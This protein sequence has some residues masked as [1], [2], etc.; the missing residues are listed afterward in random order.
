MAMSEARM[1]RLAANAALLSG[2]SVVVGKS[3]TGKPVAP[4]AIPKGELAKAK[5]AYE[6]T[7]AVLDE[8]ERAIFARW[9]ETGPPMTERLETSDRTV[10]VPVISTH[11]VVAHEV[12]EHLPEWKSGPMIAPTHV[13]EAVCFDDFPAD[14][15]VLAQAAWDARAYYLALAT[16]KELLKSYWPN[17]GGCREGVMGDL[18]DEIASIRGVKTAE[19]TPE[20]TEYLAKLERILV[21]HEHEHEAPLRAA[22]DLAVRQG[23]S[24]VEAYASDAVC[25]HC[26]GTSILRPAFD[27]PD[28]LRREWREKAATRADHRYVVLETIRR[29][30]LNYDLDLGRES[31]AEYRKRVLRPVSANTGA[32]D[33][34]SKVHDDSGGSGQRWAA[35]HAQY[36]I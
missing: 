9:I 8:A 20:Q 33:L 23:R 25:T 28:S 31:W 5:Y 12:Q 7:Y 16:D 30:K 17:R 18:R 11:N 15:R 26:G 22:R 10:E 21:Q 19:R 1:R 27:A 3:E 32:K 6:H 13:F 14:R 24:P 4:P 35:K 29:G 2:R 36:R 34:R